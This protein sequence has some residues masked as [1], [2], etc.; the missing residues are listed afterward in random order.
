MEFKLSEEQKRVGLLM[1][2]R[3]DEGPVTLGYLR[4]KLEDSPTLADS[5]WGMIEAGVVVERRDRAMYALTHEGRGCVMA[6]TAD[7]RRAH[8]APPEPDDDQ[9]PA[10]ARRR[11]AKG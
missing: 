7:Q 1:L 5:L 10:G 9:E 2:E 6:Q 3:Y 11:R 8:A 4:N